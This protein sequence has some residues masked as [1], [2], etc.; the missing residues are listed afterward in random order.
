MTTYMETW[1]LPI[2]QRAAS[3]LPLPLDI[4][5][6]AYTLLDEAGVEWHVEPTAEHLVIHC[7]LADDGLQCDIDRLRT[8]LAHHHEPHVM[9]GACIALDARRG[10]LRLVQAYAS[11]SGALHDLPAALQRLQAVRRRLLPSF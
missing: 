7:R 3:S 5:A 4:P 10:V 1:A 8:L 9:D 11:D 6:A 2:L